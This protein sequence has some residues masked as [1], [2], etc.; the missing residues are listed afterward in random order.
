MIVST[1]GPEAADGSRSVPPAVSVVVP[2]YQAASTLRELCARLVAALDDAGL[3]H[4]LLLVDDG[5]DD[6]TWALISEL[7]AAGS[8][9]VG[10]RLARNFGQSAAWCAGIERASAAVVA[11]IDADLDTYPEDL[12]LLVA[13]VL[14]GAGVANG[15][16][17]GRHWKRGFPSRLFNHRARRL[18]ITST[19]TGC[20][21]VAMEATVAREVLHHGDLRRS[22]RFKALLESLTDRVVEVPVRAGP[23]SRSSHRMA[24]LLSAGLELELAHRRTVFLGASAGGAAT[25]V[26]A[27]VATVVLVVLAATAHVPWW[28]PGLALVAALAG[29]T[30]ATVGMAANLILRNL[31]RTSTPFYRVAE[32]VPGSPRT[33]AP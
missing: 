25:A 18:G 23:P 8:S 1:S 12:P 31:H 6:G 9:V 32:V 24:D 7:A 13:A 15:A 11:T 3:T 19:D 17:Q 14:D 5:S 20:G 22:Y 33:T 27:G 26:V 29:A 2:A 16:R 30:L 4:E 10:V 28:S 21:M